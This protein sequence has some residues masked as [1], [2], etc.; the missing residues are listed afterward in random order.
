MMS[1]SGAHR[2]PVGGAG[3]RAAAV[4]CNAE[5]NRDPELDRAPLRRLAGAAALWLL[6][7]GVPAADPAP[8]GTRGAS[9]T[10]EVTGLDGALRENVLAH[11]SIERQREAPGLSGPRIEALHRRAPAEIRAGLE[12]LGHYEP[13]IDA[14]LERGEAGWNARYRVA[15]GPAV[16]V[17][18]VDVRI[19][20]PGADDPVFTAAA[21]AFPLRAGDVL[22]HARYETG[23]QT[24]ARLAAERGYFD[25]RFVTSEVRVDV[26]RRSARIL[27]VYDSGS[28]Y[29]FGALT[30]PDTALRRGF[31]ERFVPFAPGD[32]YRAGDLLDL[33]A[34]LTD[35]DYF[36]SVQVEPHRQRA[37]DGEVPVEVE[38]EL[39]KR[40]RFAIGAG[41]GTDTG[42]RGRGT[43][44]LRYVNERG[45]RLGLDTRISP[46]LRSLSGRYS[47]PLSDPRRDELA[48]TSSV[49]EED[50]DASDSR[51]F[52]IGAVHATTRRGWR[53]TVSLDYLLESFDVGEDTETSALLVPGLRWA[54]TWA[55]DPIY[56][57]RGLRLALALTGAHTS[58][59]S[60]V[61]F[62]QLRVEGKIVRALTPEL[63]VIGRGELGATT[64]SNFDRLP[65]TQ[66]F[67]AGGDNSLRGFDFRELGPRNAAGDVIGG[68]YLAVGSVEL[69]RRVRGNWS[70]ALF[71][72]FGNAFDDFSDPM[73]YSVGAGVRWLSPVG[74]VRVDLAVGVSDESTPVR[75]HIVIGPDL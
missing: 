10:V 30:L 11:L 6:A 68:K 47:M 75:L 36:Q 57:R 37:H 25:A 72:D 44:D 52:Q 38:L 67:F 46:V 7:G 27:V 53:E 48:F 28:R 24:L 21:A 35:S 17:S 20:G 51:K 32:P 15:P 45:H 8:D 66:R 40:H 74:L 12:A 54:R 26:E 55:D 50:T 60:D 34:A 71:S 69:E 4:K 13:V 61:S 42:P 73:E 3:S 41:F 29:R 49:L 39:R 43:W 19:T 9:L 59:L 23:K 56:V 63:R 58:V 18:E 33:Q 2:G 70:A 16:T 62:V 1:G 64:V 31:I 14:A 65:A 5:M 22:D